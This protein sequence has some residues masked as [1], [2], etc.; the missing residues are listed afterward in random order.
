[1]SHPLGVFYL[2]CKTCGRDVDV[3]VAETVWP[4]GECPVCGERGQMEVTWWRG[5]I[6]DEKVDGCI[7]VVDER[8]A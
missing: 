3:A 1:M 6:V 5:F 7:F 2:H 4:E 8:P